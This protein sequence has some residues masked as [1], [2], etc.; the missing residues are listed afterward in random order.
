MRKSEDDLIVFINFDL[1]FGE[2][3]EAS[4]VNHVLVLNCFLKEV[5]N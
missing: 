2:V 4:D 1:I 5:G 3:V